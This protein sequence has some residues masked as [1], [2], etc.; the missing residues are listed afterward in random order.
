ME[1]MGLIFLLKELL[2]LR[3]ATDIILVTAG[4]YFLYRTLLRLGTWKIVTGILLAIFFFS[5][6]SLLD[7]RG[8]EWIYSNLSPVAVIALIIIFQPELRKVFERAASMRR[9]EMS[10]EG[11]E[12][13]QII[14]G[15][16]IK[17]AEQRRGAIVVLPGKEPIRE[18][19]SGGYALDAM[20]SFPLLMSIF[21]PNSPGH[22]GALTIKDGR[23]ARFG[24][25][26]PISQTIRLPKDLGTRH[27]AAM[28]LAEK[29]DALVLVVSEERGVI[30]VF[31]NGLYRIVD[32]RED[33]L[34]AVVDHWKQTASSSIEIPAGGLR[35]P[36]IAQI[37]ASLAVALAFWASLTVSQAEVL[38]KV[39]TVPVEYTVTSPSLVLV[40]DKEKE[41][42]L[43]LAGSK[44]ALSS[45]SPSMISVK[46]DLFKAGA[47]KQSFLISAE[48]VRL[49]RD[50]QLVDVVPSSV[51]L[52]LAAI[53][54]KELMVK[55]QLVGS[56][57][58]N[59]KLKAVEV[60]PD[61]IM[62]LVPS[63]RHADEV[64]SVI[65]TPIYLETVT[66]DTVIYCKIISR[67]SIQPQ[68]KRWPDVEVHIMLNDAAVKSPN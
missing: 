51:D 62:A 33:I 60:R 23:F 4:L 16:L 10:S 3:A 31:Q 19:L 57:P 8:I 43:H 65:T 20:P 2:S 46:I 13:P 64:D 37:S 55:P 5:A 67:P 25:R 38:E 24:A 53:V 63:E 44:S 42:R 12:L 47:G 49:P 1:K 45:L 36:M 41:V 28:G 7:L 59:L 22:D 56:L 54:E 30:S 50:V 39:I 66:K 21:D 35:W 26:L 18:W 15:A 6:A 32:N 17:L 29:S 61:K 34:S 9:I 58:G 14:A 27:H 52:T 68:D 48:N 40:G 11:D